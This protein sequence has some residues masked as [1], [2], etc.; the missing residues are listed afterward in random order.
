MAPVG[1]GPGWTWLI[2]ARRINPWPQRV[3][4]RTAVE[5]DEPRPAGERAGYALGMVAAGSV[6]A[7]LESLV[8][9]TPARA[10]HADPIVAQVYETPVGPMLGAAVDEGLCLLEF[11]DRRAL[12]T[13]LAEL[14]EL[15][16]RPALSAG[17]HA[18]GVR[19][20]AQMEAELRAYFAGSLREFGTRLFTPGT[21]FEQAVWQEL[22]RIPYGKTCSYGDMAIKLGKP[23]AARA[24]GR[25]NGRNRIAIAIPCHRVIESNGK[26]RGYGGGL[27]RKR[28][29]LD[30]EQRSAGNTGLL[31]S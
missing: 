24:V 20:L 19:F 1:G 3:Q 6:N 2:A 18:P 11:V 4:G 29:L 31:F 16:D 17:G 8:A 21:P 14:V 27:E 28:F 22:L 7:V 13:E 15:L 26:L 10:E 23:G 9:K 12:R 30:H 5:K 25:A